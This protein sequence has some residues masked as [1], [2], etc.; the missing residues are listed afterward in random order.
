MSNAKNGSE[1]HLQETSKR[2][3]KYLSILFAS[4][5]C[6]L[7]RHRTETTDFVCYLAIILRGLEAPEIQSAHMLQ[8]G[9]HTDPDRDS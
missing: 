1:V 4:R 7:R 5:G 2:R 6:L 3:M 9:L 8:G